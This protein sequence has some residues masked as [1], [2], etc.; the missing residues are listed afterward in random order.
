MSIN[1]HNTI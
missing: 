1:N